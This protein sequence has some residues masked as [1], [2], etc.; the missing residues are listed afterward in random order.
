MILSICIP[1]FN[2]ADTLLTLL[3]SIT[4]QCDSLNKNE[5]EVVI[6]DNHSTDNTSE[7]VADAESKSDFKFRYIVHAHNTGAMKNMVSTIKYASGDFCWLMGSDDIFE[8]GSINRVLEVLKKY[9]AI[10][11]L[12]PRFNIY[13]FTLTHKSADTSRPIYGFKNEEL[14]TN[15]EPVSHNIVYELGFFS[16]LIFNRKAWNEVADLPE[17][18]YNN[19]LHVNKLIKIAKKYPIMIL[20]DYLVGYR[21]GNDSLRAEVGA[22]E[23]TRVMI[24]DYEVVIKDALSKNAYKRS[25]RQHLIFH[26]SGSLGDIQLHFSLMNKIRLFK[27]LYLYYKTDSV[28]WKNISWRIFIPAGVVNAVLRSRAKRNALQMT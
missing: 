4:N 8:P 11:L 26:V 22:F 16:I 9:P 25:M 21:Q 17:F 2:R 27:V 23:R 5:V 13:D 15:F 12:V 6:C 28:F 10:N 18:E 7:V 19:Y 14:I 1:T 20:H 3:N 24:E